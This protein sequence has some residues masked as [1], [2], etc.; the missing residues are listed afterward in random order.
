MRLA[1]N[2]PL[3]IILGATAVGKTGLGIAIAQQV[4][5]EIINADSRQTYQ[6][7]DIGTAKP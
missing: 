6:Y 7:M 3:L 1:G 4:G 5:G 2:P